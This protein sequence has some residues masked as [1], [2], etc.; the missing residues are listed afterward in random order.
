LKSGHVVRV[1]GR[2]LPSLRGGRGDIRARLIVWVPP[3]VTQSDRKLLDELK[4]SD[5]FRPPRPGRDLFD[6]VKDA[7]AG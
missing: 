3:R 2:G 4:R 7:F 6:R 1:R 5:A